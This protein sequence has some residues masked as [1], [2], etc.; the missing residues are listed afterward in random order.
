MNQT[1]A[2]LQSLAILASIVVVGSIY[3]LFSP[4]RSIR[5][6]SRN[7]QVVAEYSAYLL[8]IAIFTFSLVWLFRNNPFISELFP[9]LLLF[10]GQG[11][12]KSHAKK[13]PGLME[14]C[15]QYAKET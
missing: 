11:T 6:D 15:V 10:A 2:Q 4:S 3:L 7:R 9:F 13:R 5:I 1:Y 12:L 14:D 8:V